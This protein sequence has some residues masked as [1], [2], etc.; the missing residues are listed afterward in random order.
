LKVCSIIH[1]VGCG[2]RERER[3]PRATAAELSTASAGEGKF[4]FQS[5]SPVHLCVKCLSLHPYGPLYHPLK[6][7]KSSR[8]CGGCGTSD[9][10]HDIDFRR[11]KKFPCSLWRVNG[12]VCVC[13]CVC[14]CVCLCTPFQ[15][16]LDAGCLLLF[17]SRDFL[18]QGINQNCVCGSL[19][20]PAFSAA[21]AARCRTSLLPFTSFGVPGTLRNSSQEPTVRRPTKVYDLLPAKRGAAEAGLISLESQRRFSRRTL[22]QRRQKQ[23]LQF[24]SLAQ[25][26]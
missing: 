4:H 24:S 5:L 10:M 1:N 11:P 19:S 18:Q 25:V 26:F 20:Q 17:L 14:E 15:T 12:V 16:A 22:I 21:A 7:L 3:P 13:V 9:A 2:G 23:N 8:F 6:R